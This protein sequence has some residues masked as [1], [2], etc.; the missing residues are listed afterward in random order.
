MEM[1]RG[2]PEAEE[3]N[4]RLWSVTDFRQQVRFFPICLCT[5]YFSGKLSIPAIVFTSGNIY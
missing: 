3:R 2:Y 4:A 5:F 1:T